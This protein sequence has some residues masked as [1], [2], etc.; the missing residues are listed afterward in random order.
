MV[1]VHRVPREAAR[2]VEDACTSLRGETPEAMGWLDRLTHAHQRQFAVELYAAL[3][4]MNLSSDPTRVIELLEAWEATAEID[5]A[6]EV[7]EGLRRAD[8]HYR[9]WRAV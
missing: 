4:E 9:E 2:R 5:A 3:S 7:A 1:L 8:K 6:P